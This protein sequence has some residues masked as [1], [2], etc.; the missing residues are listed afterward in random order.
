MKKHLVLAMALGLFPAAAFA[1]FNVTPRQQQLLAEIPTTSSETAREIFTELGKDSAKLVPELVSKLTT[2]KSDEDTTARFAMGGLVWTVGH[3]GSEADKKA[4]ARVIADSIAKAADTEPKQFLIEQLQYMGDDSVTD[5]LYPL[6]TDKDLGPRTIRT[7]TA[8]EPEGFGEVAVSKLN[9]ANT[10][11]VQSGLLLSIARLA[12]KGQAAKVAPY[13]KSDDRY[14]RNAALDALAAI[15]DPASRAA[16]KE[17]ADAQETFDDQLAPARYLNYAEN[18]AKAG[19]KD[20]AAEIAREVASAKHTSATQHLV[21]LALTTLTDVSGEAALDDL[22]AHVKDDHEPTRATALD[23]INR[24]KTPAVTARLVQELNNAPDPEVTV[25]ILLGLGDRGDAAAL[26]AITPKFAEKDVTIATTAIDAAGEIAR[27]QAL[28]AYLDA[29]KAEN[30]KAVTDAIINQLRRVKSETLQPAVGAAIP[31]SSTEGKVALIKLLGER[32][33]VSQK[34]VVFTAAQSDDAKVRAAAYDALGQVAESADLPRLRDMILAADS[35]A[36]RKSARQAYAAVAKGSGDPA[37]NAKLLTD[38]LAAANPEGKAVLMETLAAIGDPS[39]I[40]AVQQIANSAAEPEVQDAA[41]RALGDW[42]NPAVVDVLAQIA[43]KSKNEKHQVL[44]VRG[45]ARLAGEE[46]DPAKKLDL[47]TKAGSLARRAEEQ[48]AVVAQIAEVKTTAALYA[49]APFLANKE[50]GPDAAAAAVK[51]AMP[52]TEDKDKS[53]DTGLQGAETIAILQ[54]CLPYLTDE[55]RKPVEK[56]IYELIRQVESVK[57]PTD[58]DGFVK[59]FNGTDLTGWCG[60]TDVYKVNN[61][62]IELPAGQRGNLF[63]AR[64]YGDFVLQFEFKIEA[65]GNNGVGIRSPLSGDAAYQGMEIQILDNND[66][67]YKDLKEWQRH[68]S[69]YGIAAAKPTQLKIGDWNQEEIVVNG[70]N[71]KVTVNGEVINDVN[72]DEAIKNGFISNVDHP[73]VHRNRGHIGFLGHKDPIQLRNIR[74]KNIAND[75]PPEGFTK[76][77]NGENLDGWKGLVANPIKRKAMAPEELEK[78][79]AKADEEMHQHW[80]VIDGILFFDGLGSHMCTTKDYKNF[81][82]YV[83]WAIPPGGD[84]GLYLRGSP[85]VQ[86]WDPHYW[87]EGSG[88]LYNNQKTT[89]KP[90]TMADNPIGQWNTFHIKMVDDK[91]TVDLNG[92]RVVENQVLEN[93]WDRKLPIFP[94]EQI[95]LQSHGSPAWWRNIYIKELP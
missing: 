92:K 35:S 64:Q 28:P 53:N 87:P 45:L 23:N 20:V 84:N 25:G 75:A 14:I 74:L 55:Q 69:V 70:R 17:A 29:L 13:V 46:K 86:I 31:A 11:A 3:S 5:V 68:G 4:L 56:Y 32:H 7:V 37:A 58:S 67:K 65:G 1:Q 26:A 36:E 6:L 16:L 8:L 63:T 89:S 15:G 44:A 27:D 34:E 24:F 22:F 90:L 18:L 85:Q 62:V 73:G 49:L 71:V 83:D 30:E 12:P 48:K 51:L 39:S 52:N 10:T 47:L 88:G 80:D 40:A 61:G 21:G 9:D 76:L 91:V 54:N 42:Q 33:G 19:K 79:Q 93:Y 38:A 2:E 77:Y 94:V 95:E 66:P 72:L 82:M 81:E 60:A 50:I 59:L 43:G 78:K 41:V 57:L